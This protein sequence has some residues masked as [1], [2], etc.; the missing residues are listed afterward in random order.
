MEN[1]ALAELLRRAADVIADMNLEADRPQAE[2][3]PKR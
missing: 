3:Q 2:T 1:V